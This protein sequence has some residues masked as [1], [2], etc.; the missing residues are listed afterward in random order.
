MS[1]P[2]QVQ[3][4]N[5]CC[6][7]ILII[8][9]EFSRN[10]K[11]SRVTEIAFEIC[12]FLHFRCEKNNLVVCLFPHFVGKEKRKKKQSNLAQLRT[13]HF[14]LGVPVDHSTVPMGQPF[15]T[16]KEKKT[17]YSYTHAYQQLGR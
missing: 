15:S 5:S 13:D 8:F 17:F 6:I 2:R 3:E 14:S 16:Q 11:K 1:N 12:K 4:S 9:E 7:I 10:L